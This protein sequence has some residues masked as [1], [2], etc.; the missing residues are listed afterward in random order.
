MSKTKSAG[1]SKLGRD[2][3][4]KRLGVKKFGG[5]IVKSG[6]ILIRQRGTRF[7]PGINV[8]RGADDT[9]YAT[10]NGVVKFRTVRKTKFDGSQR[11]AKVIEIH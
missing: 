11:R 5:Q 2:S 7:L 8:R 10:R 4:S 6:M 3:R 1:T 9:L